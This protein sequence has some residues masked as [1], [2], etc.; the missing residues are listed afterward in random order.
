MRHRDVPMM[1]L[2]VVVGARE[3]VKLKVCRILEKSEPCGG[4]CRSLE[5]SNNYVV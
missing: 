3:S 2:V 1:Q 4:F 5:I